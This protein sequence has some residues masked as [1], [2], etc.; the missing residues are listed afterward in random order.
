[1]KILNTK[2]ELPDFVFNRPE[3]AKAAAFLPSIGQIPA[4]HIKKFSFSKPCGFPTS[5]FIFA[6]INNETLSGNYIK[7]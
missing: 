7:F 1:M 6:S 4:Q 3:H 2:T 5:Q